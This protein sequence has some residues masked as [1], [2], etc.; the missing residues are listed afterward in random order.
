MKF[1]DEFGLR[2][3]GRIYPNDLRKRT[4]TIVQIHF[5][6]FLY[7]VKNLLFYIKTMPVKIQLFLRQKFIYIGTESYGIRIG[8]RSSL[9]HHRTIEVWVDGAMTMARWCDSA[10]TMVRWRDNAMTMER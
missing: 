2:F 10:M 7:T 4:A 9:S 8:P 1:R 3:P 6:F 5:E